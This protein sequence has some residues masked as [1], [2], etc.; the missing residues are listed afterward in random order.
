MEQNTNQYGRETKGV[1]PHQ[2]GLEGAMQNWCEVAD[3]LHCPLPAAQSCTGQRYLSSTPPIGCNTQAPS[4]EVPPVPG[5]LCH[6]PPHQWHLLSP[7]LLYCLPNSLCSTG[8]DAADTALSTPA[9]LGAADGC[10]EVFQPHPSCSVN[11]GS[12][13]L[14]RLLLG[15][16]SNGWHSP[17]ERPNFTL[18]EMSISL[19]FNSSP[20]DLSIS[21]SIT[22]PTYWPG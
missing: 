5:C 14:S 13:L 4:G 18:F 15:T 22:S 3:G 21:L 7:E 2:T 12:L 6:Y 10:T 1:H 11:K 20:T 19:T 9:L 16:T 8:K 17:R